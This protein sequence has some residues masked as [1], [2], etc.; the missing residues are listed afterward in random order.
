M[1]TESSGV[2]LKEQRKKRA[3]VREKERYKYLPN[4]QWSDKSRQCHGSSAA[5][6]RSG[7]ASLQVRHYRTKPDSKG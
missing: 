5:V 7:R 1:N 6:P 3:V 2:D 4:P